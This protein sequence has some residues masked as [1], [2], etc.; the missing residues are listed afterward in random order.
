VNSYRRYEPNIFVPITRSWAFE[1]RST[2]LRVPIGPGDTRRIEHRMAG[3]DANPYLALA[4][5]LAG[6]HHGIVNEIDPGAP[7]E[8]NA[9]T[10]FDAGL[11]MRPR[12]ALELMA[13][14]KTLPWYFGEDY[15]KL[16]TACKE[17]EYDE[18]EWLISP[19][20]YD[21]YLQSD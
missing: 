2:A 3:A 21:W 1:N 6:I 18:F 19:H 16:Y 10:G 5:M 20:E 12:R 8:G 7:H 15:P 4:S 9:G 11:P 13:A 17:A 14:S